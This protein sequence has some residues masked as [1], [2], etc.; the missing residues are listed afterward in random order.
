[1]IKLDLKPLCQKV[2]DKLGIEPL[3]IRFEE[4]LDDSRLYIKEQYVAI[5]KKF[6]NNYVEC[7]KAIAHE[8]RHVFQIFYAN[9]FNDDRAKRWIAELSTLVNTSNMD[10]VGS[11]Y[12]SQELELDAFSFTKHYLD[13]YE[14]IKIKNNISGY[15]KIIDKYIKV[16]KTIM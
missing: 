13:K 7:A 9:M 10:K 6:E 12:I 14:S 11:N 5:N 1:M 16:N 2:A 3:D 15:D 8:Y 4:M